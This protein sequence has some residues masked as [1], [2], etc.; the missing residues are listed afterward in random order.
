MTASNICR[1]ITDAVKKPPR[2]SFIATLITSDRISAAR[3]E[4]RA[5][6]LFVALFFVQR[7]D[8]AFPHKLMP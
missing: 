3:L 1:E 7:S 2:V 4:G 6:F 5:A 8:D